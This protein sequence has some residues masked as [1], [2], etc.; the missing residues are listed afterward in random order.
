MT[1]TDGW[2]ID[3]AAARTAIS[4]AETEA[5]GW[6]DLEVSLTT[7]LSDAFSALS[8]HGPKTAAA[9]GKVRTNP[10]EIDL[11]A[12]RQ[13]VQRAVQGT[14]DAIAAYERGDEAMAA[15][16]ENSVTE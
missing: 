15:S 4:A 16:Y 14:R 8:A 9:L 10:F 2:R 6:S 13:H 1:M 3:P 11:L 5:D 12:A 7:A